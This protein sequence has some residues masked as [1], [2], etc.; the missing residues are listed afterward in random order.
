MAFTSS[1]SLH[2]LLKIKL[3][4]IAYSLPLSQFA[5][6]ILATEESEKILSM[7]SREKSSGE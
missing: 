6:R 5:F 7:K 2:S 1:H 4:S 3:M